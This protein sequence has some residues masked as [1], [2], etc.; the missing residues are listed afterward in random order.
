ML[1]KVNPDQIEQL[2]RQLDRLRQTFEETNTGMYRELNRLIGSVESAYHENNVRSAARA[3]RDRL[4]KIMSLSMQLDDHMRSKAK[5][6]TMA[7]GQYRQT[8]KEMLALTRAKKPPVFTLKGLLQSGLNRF[9]G[10]AAGDRAGPQTATTAYPSILQ[11]IKESLMKIQ[12]WSL[13]SRLAPVKDDARIAALLASLDIGNAEEQLN[14]RRELEIIAKS[15]EEIA[16]S[17][18]AYRIYMAYGNRMYMEQAHQEAEK[19]RKVLADLGVS[20]EWFK[21]E[22][23]LA[24][25]QKGSPLDAC[26]YNPLKQDRSPMP[27]ESE[28]RLVIAAG[29]LNAVYREWARSHYDQIEAAVLKAAE[30]RRNLQEQLDTYNREVPEEDIRKMQQ[31]LKDMNIYHGEVTGQYNEEFLIAVA[32]YQHIANTVSSVAAVRRDMFGLEG[33]QFEVDGKITKELLDLGY[34]ERGLGIRNNPDLDTRGMS[35]AFTTVGVG[36]GIVKQIGEDAKDLIE[37]AISVQPTSLQFWTETIPGYYDLGKAIAGGEITYDDVKNTVGE[38][39]AQE[40]VVPFEQINE[41]SDKI[42]S[43]QA[44]YDDSVTYGRALTKAVM[45]LTL[46][47]GAVKSGAK[48]SAKTSKKLAELLPRI[49]PTQTPVAFTPEGSTFPIT[50]PGPNDIPPLPKN[51]RQKNFIQFYE[52]KNRRLDGE[53]GKGITKIKP[54][55]QPDPHATPKGPKTKISPKD[56]E[57]TKRSLARENQAAEILAKHGYDIEQN[58]KIEGITRNPDY[59]LEGELFDCY[60]PAEKTSARS[61]GSTIEEK[62]ITK[63]QADRVILN[64]SDWKGNTDSIVEQ[65]RNYPIEGLKEVIVITKEEKVISIYP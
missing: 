32:G 26:A 65:L 62:V 40:F 29:M 10:I 28:L 55:K 60:S 61:I 1:Q 17:Q 33:Y 49:K 7:A 56:D 25:F 36:E 64:L 16:R 3:A 35:A 22:V 38:G 20:Q 53:I 57:A 6:L 24:E 39:L 21:E 18:A 52:E 23:S 12:E 34:A 9:A 54:S 59:R 50:G 44:T 37:Y 45:A 11:L 42:F 48:L 15:F 46:V 31:Y 58:P 2:S 30:Q 4:Q 27:K 5:A 41:L 19:C 63:K 51:E 43:G 8:E 13:E 14:A 47:N